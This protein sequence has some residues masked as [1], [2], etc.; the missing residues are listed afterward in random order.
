MSQIGTMPL[1][2]LVGVG[3]RAMFRQDQGKEKFGSANGNRTRISALKGPRAN[4]CTIAPKGNLA[5]IEKKRGMHKATREIDYSADKPFAALVISARTT[6][7]SSRY[8]PY[9]GS[10]EKKPGCTGAR[11]A[12][13]TGAR[14]ESAAKEVGHSIL[15]VHWP[16]CG[17]P[18]GRLSGW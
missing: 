3:G 7:A 12:V 8:P 9:I 4:R 2:C 16:C 11:I 10:P 5:R 14:R 17:V 18:G 6:A 13:H 15:V 1:R